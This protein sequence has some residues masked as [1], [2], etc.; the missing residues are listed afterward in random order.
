MLNIGLRKNKDSSINIKNCYRLD[1]HHAEDGSLFPLN[2]SQL[3]F[4]PKRFFMV[5]GCSAGEKRGGHAHYANRTF[6][7]CA[8]GSINVTINDGLNEF[9]H[10]LTQ[11]DG[12]YVDRLV[13]DSQTYNTE[14]SI[15]I[16]FCS[17]EYDPGD[18]IED[19]SK[20]KQIIK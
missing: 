11:G 7:F 2:F 16:A 19:F 1:C 6:L 8:N 10:L 3:P 15:L 18:Y 14:D 4:T 20:F 12:V 13:W 5:S 9:T 17:I